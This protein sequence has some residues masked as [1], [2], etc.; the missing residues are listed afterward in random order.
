MDSL[1]L[2]AVNFWF[3]GSV[4]PLAADAPCSVMVTEHADGTATVCVSDPM[5]MRTS[6]TLTWNRAV[7]SVVSKPATVSSA[8]AGPSLR[9]V[10]GD[11][12]GTRGATQTIKV[13]LS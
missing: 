3:G 4:G 13:R 2:T 8:T 7:A 1:G 5:R 9:L 11:L 12:S 10:F 6:L